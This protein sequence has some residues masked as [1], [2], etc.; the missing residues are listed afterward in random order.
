MLPPSSEM[1]SVSVLFVLC[2]CVCVCVLARDLSWRDLDLIVER[3]P[4]PRYQ[5]G[6]LDVALPLLYGILLGFGG[7]LLAGVAVLLVFIHV[8]WRKPA[9]MLP[10][11]VGQQVKLMVGSFSGRSEAEQ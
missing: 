11:D 1:A 9:Q 3:A 8:S 7:T 6:P 10:P 2:V 5:K 4:V